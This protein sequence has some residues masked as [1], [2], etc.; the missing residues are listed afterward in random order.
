[1]EVKVS[2]LKTAIQLLF[3][4]VL[5]IVITTLIVEKFGWG[6]MLE[7]PLVLTSLLFLLVLWWVYSIIK[8]G[9]FVLSLKEE[10]ILFK[11]HNGEF[12]LVKWDLIES[13]KHSGQVGIS[14]RDFTPC[15]KTLMFTSGNKGE[16]ETLLYIFFKD[17][18]DIFYSSNMCN[19]VVEEKKGTNK[20]LISCL[21]NNNSANLAK[22]VLAY[23]GLVNK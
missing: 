12:Y 19:G 18:N 1:M 14:V 3:I 10:G 15:K 7:L 23:K 2:G 21:A 20:K 11:F 8:N 4:S 9:L 13:I 22:K 17:Q 5:L 6:A 16:D